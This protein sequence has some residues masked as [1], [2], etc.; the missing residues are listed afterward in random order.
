MQTEGTQAPG[1]RLSHL[2]QSRCSVM[3]FAPLSW[4]F[5]DS[6]HLPK[7]S[8]GRKAPEG[9]G[10]KGRVIG[11]A[12]GGCCCPGFL[13]GGGTELSWKSVTTFPE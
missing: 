12:E 1:G 9:W 10:R 7:G 8:G 4:F 13:P 5:G 6:R 11:A 2:P 3:L